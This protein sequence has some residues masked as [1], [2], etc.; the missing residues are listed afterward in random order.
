MLG[1]SLG[2]WASKIPIMSS[3]VW[4][5]G[6]PLRGQF[7]QNPQNMLSHTSCNSYPPRPL[8]G[9]SSTMHKWGVVEFPIG[10]TFG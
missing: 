1:M 5:S 9:P 10:R 6:Q 7:D 4:S 2:F 3:S 8:S